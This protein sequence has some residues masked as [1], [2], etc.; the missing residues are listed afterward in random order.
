LGAIVALGVLVIAPTAL[1]YSQGSE[2][3][4]WRRL[5][6]AAL[7]LYFGLLQLMLPLLLAIYGSALA[8]LACFVWSVGMGAVG[9][10]VYTRLPRAWTLLAAWLAAGGG[11]LA[12][13]M[14]S[15]ALQPVDGSSFTLACVA[16]GAFA[17]VWFGFYLAVALAFDAHNNEAGGAARIDF[18]RHFVRIKLERDRLTGYVIGFDRPSTDAARP[19]LIDVFQLV[20]GAPER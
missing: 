6:Y 9:Y 20:P 8:V 15:A 2:R 1:A 16:G 10:F 5:G 13:L 11:A 19:R 14:T 18:Y 17:C 3:S 4:L 12:L 7:G